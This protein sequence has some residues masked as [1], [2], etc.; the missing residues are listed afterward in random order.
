ME[1]KNEVLNLMVRHGYITEEEANT[2]KEIE[3]QDTFFLN[4]TYQSENSSIYCYF[5]NRN[6]IQKYFDLHNQSK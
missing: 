6:L 4:F 2:A 1:R 3:V 5:S